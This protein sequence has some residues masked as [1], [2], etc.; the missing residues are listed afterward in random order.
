MGDTLDLVCEENEVF[1]SE[2]NVCRDL[3]VINVV[4]LDEDTVKINT[5]PLDTI[6]DVKAKIEEQEGIP[7]N[8]IFLQ[9][10]G[11]R[12]NDGK[13]TLKGYGIKHESTL[14]MVCENR[15]KRYN[16]AREKCIFREPTAAGSASL[17]ATNVIGGIIAISI[18][19]LLVAVI[20]KSA[21][22]I[23]PSE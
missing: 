1:D 18:L 10:E 23:P 19:I 22:A 9:F 6:D 2:E 5:R 15:F 20:L 14:V 11:L 12:L 17:G 4:K 8:E 21:V 16:I 7:V 13:E 3:M